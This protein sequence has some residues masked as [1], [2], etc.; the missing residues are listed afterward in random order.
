MNEL[1]HTPAWQN[2]VF[3]ML[4]FSVIL[5]AVLWY[6]SS[7]PKEDREKLFQWI[8]GAFFR[9]DEKPIKAK[10]DEM[11]R[12]MDANIAERKAKQR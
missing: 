9:T 4:A 5:V 11:L 12:Q 8:S 10:S 7:L 2:L 6:V 3:G 1:M